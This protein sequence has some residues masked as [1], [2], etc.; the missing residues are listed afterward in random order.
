MP[1]KKSN[2]QIDGYNKTFPR[3][4]RELI[5]KNNTTIQ[6]VANQIGITRQA[7]SQY[8][9]G[10]TQPNG[11]T[12]LKIA[13]CFGVS[14]DYLLRGVSAENINIEKDLGLSEKSIQLIR[15][16]NSRKQRKLE[17][18]KNL[19]EM[20]DPGEKIGIFEID[21]LNI[22]L[23]NSYKSGLF[24]DFRGL[25]DLDPAAA[26]KADEF[27]FIDGIHKPFWGDELY[28][29]DFFIP[30][31]DFIRD[32]HGAVL[33]AKENYDYNK[34][35]LLKHISECIEAVF[36]H[37]K[38]VDQG[39]K[40]KYEIILESRESIPVLDLPTTKEEYENWINEIGTMNFTD[41]DF[42]D[43]ERRKEENFYELREKEL[44]K[45]YVDDNKA[46]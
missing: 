44:R 36:L 14:C 38:V 20:Y 1:A 10:E 41:E 6:A 25:C 42:T 40:K 17:S 23:E 15:I 5:E 2:T 7:V 8:C 16:F 46:E 28:D 33:S 37:D 21:T 13:D 31:A 34:T 43:E 26:E 24:Y 32:N 18:M 35:K 11:E 12:L 45:K 9:N 4:L 3:I 39:E 19:P 22:L 29:Y 30:A 27:G